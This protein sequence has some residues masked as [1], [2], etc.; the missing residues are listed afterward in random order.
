MASDFDELVERLL[1]DVAL[2]GD[3]GKLNYEATV[4]IYKVP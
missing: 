3:R 2:S 1:F 4:S